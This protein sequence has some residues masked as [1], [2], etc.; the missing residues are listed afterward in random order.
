[1]LIIKFVLIFLYSLCE[2]DILMV[3]HD[4]QYVNASWTSKPVCHTNFLLSKALSLFDLHLKTK[5]KVEIG[6]AVF[7]LFDTCFTSR[8]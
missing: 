6:C 4:V 1:M 3:R 8:L 7:H 5:K 2:N